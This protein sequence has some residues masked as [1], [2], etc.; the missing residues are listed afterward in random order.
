M[1]S[2]VTSALR[3]FALAWVVVF[4]AAPYAPAA[5]APKDAGKSEAKKKAKEETKETNKDVKKE[6]KKDP[7]PDQPILD[8]LGKRSPAEQQAWLRQ[9]EERAIHAGQLTMSPEKA[10]RHQEAVRARLHQKT[11]SWQAILDVIKNT[12]SN[13]QDAIDRM[14]RRYYTLVYDNF[15]KKP[16]E[17]EFRR[18]A[19]T[20]VYA[21][22]RQAGGPFEQHGQLLE[23]LEAAIRSAT[24]GTIASVPRKPEFKRLPSVVALASKADVSGAKQ[25]D[26][27]K[28]TDTAKPEESAKPK[29]AEKPSGDQKLASAEKST[30]E[31]AK[32]PK[33]G[34]K[35]GKGGGKRKPGGAKSQNQTSLKDV[36]KGSKQPKAEDKQRTAAKEPKTEDEKP[37]TKETLPIQKKKSVAKK[38][39]SST[40][41][42]TEA[43]KQ[44]PAIKRKPVEVAE[45]TKS[46][47][48]K[49]TEK[50][51]SRASKGTGGV[52][53][54]A[55]DLSS[56]IRGYNLTLR[57]VESGLDP[58]HA[59]SATNLESAADGLSRL[60][61]RRQ[62]LKLF[63]DL[64]PESERSSVERLSSA[65]TA[66]SQLSACITS[67][68]NR[69]IGK[70]FEGTEAERQVELKRLEALSRTVSEM[71][72]K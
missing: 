33:T 36:V 5:K 9:L 47:K 66:I 7:D 54:T 28:P 13:E 63:Y 6:P 11:V 15:H 17:Y 40:E 67:S 12:R 24:P 26:A 56:R 10:V 62:D 43:D 46:P 21:D 57:G 8:R 35:K 45:A 64:L 18:Q 31:P 42:K 14:A 3:A 23:W 27:R 72:E 48:L 25:E 1:L 59:W 53:F 50:T 41:E 70:D 2:C 60:L 39:K 34:K 44:D 38:A 30:E 37:A 61:L 68:Q 29:V 20:D 51:G 65:K 58:K 71:G 55:E 69:A 4:L 19:W 16:E 22:W 52:S 49:T 32:K